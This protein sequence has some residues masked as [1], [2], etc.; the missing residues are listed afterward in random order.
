MPVVLHA[1]TPNVNLISNY[2]PTPNDNIEPK[3]SYSSY[4][5]SKALNVSALC[6][7]FQVVNFKLRKKEETL[8]CKKYYFKS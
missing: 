8:L 5:L 4:T 1:L 3:H 6:T 7:Y 2:Q